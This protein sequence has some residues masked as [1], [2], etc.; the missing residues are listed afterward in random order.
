MYHSNAAIKD[1][2]EA[3][4]RHID[5]SLALV[6]ALDACITRQEESIA[7]PH[8]LDKINLID[9]GSGAGLPGL[10]IAVARPDWRICLLDSLNKRC[11]FN[12]AAAEAMQL[13]NIKVVWARAETAG[14]DE[15]LREQFDLV[16]ARAVAE[17][18]ILA[19]LCLPFAKVGGH[20]VAAKGHNP[21]EELQAAQQAISTLGGAYPTIESVESIAPEGKRTVV[22]VEKRSKMRAKYP[23]KPGDPKRQP[24]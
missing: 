22:I 12:N 4:S 15:N 11:T 8:S 19:E 7:M 5:D 3:V 20:W 14:R 2:E 1:R 6:P 24:L 13:D 16:T 21:D 23:R 9:I 18:R 10:V 17:L